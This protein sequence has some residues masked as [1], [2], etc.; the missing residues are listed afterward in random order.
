[1]VKYLIKFGINSMV[2]VLS[3]VQE[4]PVTG[5]LAFTRKATSLLVLFEYYN[6][7]VLE[8]PCMYFHTGWPYSTD[9]SSTI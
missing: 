4:I 7:H 6:V 9:G 1:M 8:C 2:G 3:Y 5:G